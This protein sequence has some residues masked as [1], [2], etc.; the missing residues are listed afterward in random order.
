MKAINCARDTN[1]VQPPSFLEQQLISFLRKRLDG[2]TGKLQLQLPSGVQCAFGQ[3]KPNASVTL[4][5]YR[6][7]V[8]LLFGG[9]N[10]WSE[11]YLAGEWD[12][13]DLTALVN[14]ALGYETSLSSIAKA[15]FFT[16]IL[17]NLY[18]WRRDNS[19]KGSRRNIAAH[20]DLGNNFYKEWLDPGMTYS[21]ALFESPHQT[22]QEA[23]HNKNARILDML[24]AQPNAHIAEIGCGWGGFAEQA[25]K[26]KALRVHGVT[27]S[28]EQLFWAKSRITAAGL[29]DQVSLSLTDYRD[30]VHRY[31]GIVSIEMFE[32]VGEAHWDTYFQTLQRILKPGGNVVLQIITIDD[33]RFHSYRKNADFIQRYVFPGGMLPS[34]EAL[35]QKFDQHGFELQ[36]KLLF[37]P[38]YAETLRRWRDAFEARWDA[39]KPLGFD[40]RFYRLWRYYLAYCEGGF[41]SGSINVGLYKLSLAKA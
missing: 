20:Y 3:G 4:H 12:S 16:Q 39:I 11:S 9:I 40:D 18:H 23:Q 41:D 27:L 7:L 24:D 17:H 28:Q 37:G 25:A 15:S 31:D 30:L 33:E 5:T 29:S 32:A 10:G 19:K 34:I 35:Q 6:P 21:A 8:R 2:N 14:W 13:P 22:L 38:D 1:P 36:A 26:D